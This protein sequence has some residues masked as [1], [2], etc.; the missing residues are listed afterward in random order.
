MK[1]KENWGIKGNEN[2]LGKFQRE[3]TALHVRGILEFDHSH[4]SEIKEKSIF[5]TPIKK[6]IKTI[7]LLEAAFNHFFNLSLQHLYSMLNLYYRSASVCQYALEFKLWKWS[8]KILKVS[9][10]TK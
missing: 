10:G 7:H 5:W 1:A 6:W 8:F 4:L 3:W 9:G 2:L